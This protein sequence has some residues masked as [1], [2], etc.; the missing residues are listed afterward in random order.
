MQCSVYTG[1]K[2]PLSR[3][4]TVSSL[5]GLRSLGRAAYNPCNPAPRGF[6]RPQR[7]WTTM[8]PLPLPFS[9]VGTE[10]RGGGWGEVERQEVPSGSP[11]GW[12]SSRGDPSPP[13]TATYQKLPPKRP[14][15]TEDKEHPCGSCSGSIPSFAGGSPSAGHVCCF[16]GTMEKLSARLGTSVAT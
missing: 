10:S 2:A 1:A 16:Q 15:K 5:P 12:T 13:S 14:V 6:H 8:L 7:R 11:G 4:L 3:A 9:I